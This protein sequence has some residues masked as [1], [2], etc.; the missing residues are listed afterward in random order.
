MRL[1]VVLLNLIYSMKFTA[2]FKWFWYV[3]IY[4]CN[5]LAKT[6]PISFFVKMDTF[7]QESE[8]DID[9]IKRFPPL[10]SNFKVF[11]IYPRWCK[12]D[13]HNVFFVKSV[14]VIVEKRGFDASRFRQRC[15][16]VW[17]IFLQKVRNVFA[18]FSLQ[19]FQTITKLHVFIF[20]HIFSNH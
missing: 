8:I 10:P 4:F 11:L 5:S 17:H 6:Y 14:G 9:F 13:W 7:Q 20:L 15:Y 2:K 18:M 3:W 1:T 16:F 19:S 12:L